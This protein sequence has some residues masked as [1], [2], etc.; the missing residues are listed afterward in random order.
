MRLPNYPNCYYGLTCTP[1]TQ[2]FLWLIY[3]A[4]TQLPPRRI[5][6]L[7]LIT[8]TTNWD[9]HAAVRT[10]PASNVWRGINM[11]VSVF[12]MRFALLLNVRW[13]QECLWI[14]YHLSPPVLGVWMRSLKQPI[15]CPY[16]WCLTYILCQMLSWWTK[17]FPHSINVWDRLTNLIP[18][19]SVYQTPSYEHNLTLLAPFATVCLFEHAIY[20]WGGLHHL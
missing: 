8:F 5:S 15:P 10:K 16:Y 18:L 3:S 2:T 14:S 20:S 9:G 6:I 1:N 11:Q 17:N 19:C 12:N 7:A 13:Y 4:S